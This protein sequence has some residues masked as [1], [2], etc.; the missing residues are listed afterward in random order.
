[1]ERKI[2]TTNYSN[3]E[4]ETTI[5]ATEA[6]LYDFA[7]LQGRED[8]EKQTEFSETIFKIKIL[9]PVQ[10][11]VQNL[12]D[13]VRKVLLPAS[14]VHDVNEAD[15]A[16][17]KRIQVIINES[18]DKKHKKQF[19]KRKQNPLTPDPLKLKYGR[20]FFPATVLFG[21]ADGSVAYTNFR[22][23]SYSVSLAFVTALAIVLAV[24]FS[25]FGYTTWIKKAI[26]EQQRSVRI[27]IILSIAFV[28]FLL[29]SNLRAVAANNNVDIGINSTDVI[30]PHTSA[31]NGLPIALAS[32]ALFTMVLFLSLRF[33]MSKK[34]RLE[35]QEYFKL[36]KEV[37][38]LDTE[39]NA[40]EKERKEIEQAIALQKRDARKIFDYSVNSIRRCK[41]V[42][43]NTVSKYKQT[44]AR[45][46]NDI[47]P[48]FFSIPCNFVY[49]DA[50]YFQQPQKTEQL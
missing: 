31:I 21:I 34:E 38:K 37:E 39:I 28:F 49:D 32:F 14:R 50:I 17:Q 48:D 11:K 24:A 23:G 27:L 13:L 35:E 33:W 19:F 10:A 1:M 45:F 8:S 46:N 7:E 16:A 5:T 2:I 43:L 25:H 4:I 3:D 9:E 44:F 18:N 41:N 29:I 12:I 6:E 20:L 42:G 47:V 26:T 36:G 40:L 22:N 30:A 15:L